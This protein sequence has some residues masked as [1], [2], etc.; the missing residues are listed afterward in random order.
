MKKKGGVPFTKSSDLCTLSYYF[1]L[2]FNK[3]RIILIFTGQMRKQK[4]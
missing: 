1:F 3:V 4:S 2:E